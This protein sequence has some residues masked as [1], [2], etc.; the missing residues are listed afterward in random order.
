[1]HEGMQVFLLFMGGAFLL[2]MGILSGLLLWKMARNEINLSTILNE[3]NGDASISR[4]QLLLFSMVVAVGLFLSMLNS[5]TLPDIPNSILVLL[6]IS[7]S[8]YAAGKGISFSR[9]EGIMKPGQI[10][11]DGPPPDSPAVVPIDPAAASPA[12]AN[13][14]GQ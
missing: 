11:P 9:V 10:P 6:G 2:F 8:T 7:A 1:M 5:L 12:P 4:F 13:G 3:S 14:S